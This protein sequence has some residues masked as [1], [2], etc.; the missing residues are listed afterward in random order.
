MDPIKP[1]MVVVAFCLSKIEDES[2]ITKLPI[3][4][5]IEGASAEKLTWDGRPL[6]R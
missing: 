6:K 2:A 4:I 5:H 3:E 1:G